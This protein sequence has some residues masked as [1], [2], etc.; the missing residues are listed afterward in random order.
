MVVRKIVDRTVLLDQPVDKNAVRHEQAEK[1]GKQ[2]DHRFF[3]I[4]QF[5]ENLSS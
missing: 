1:S 4:F 3:S 2:Q 5:G